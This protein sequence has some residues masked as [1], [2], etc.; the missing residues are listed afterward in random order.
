MQ[1]PKSDFIWMNGKFIRWSDANIH[2]TTHALHY[3]SSIFEGIRCYNTKNGS[4]VFRLKEHVKR[5]FE[6]AKIYRMEI[7]YSEEDIQKAIINTVKQNKLDECYIRPLA[8]RNNE[9]IGLNPLNI[10]VDVAII[11]WRWEKYLGDKAIDVKISSWS[12]M[13]PN[14]FPALA[15]A[16]GNYINSQ[17]AKIDAFLDGYAE[18]IMLNTNGFV[19]E[20]SGENLFLVRENILYTPGL[21]NSVLK[22]ITRDSVIH[23]AKKIG[24]TLKEETIP[25]EMLY[26]ADEL[27]LTGTATE[28]IQ[29]KSADR[30][31]IGNGK[32]GPI[33][34]KIKEEFGSILENG[35]PVEWFS[36]V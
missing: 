23:I 27:F 20:G 10:G 14:T 19:S 6:S 31:K 25:R 8:Y 4:A 13:A 29:I 15:K 2:I 12:R 9:G 24:Y 17:L 11:V 1:K 21:F 30:I 36:F 16:G 22:G 5:F 28:I 26:I 18:A 32:I 35:K 3:G 33:T 7:P 34:K